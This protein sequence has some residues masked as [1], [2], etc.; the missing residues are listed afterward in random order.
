MIQTEQDLYDGNGVGDG[1]LPQVT[2]YADSSSSDNRVTQFA[3][4][5]RDRLVATKSGVQASEDTTTHRP[6]MYYDLDNLGEVTGISHYDGDGVTLTNTKPSA[7]LL[8]AHEADSYDD[9]GRVYQTQQYDVNQTTR[10]LSP[11]AL[12]PNCYYD[13]RGDLIA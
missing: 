9:Q 6:I 10:A 13:H 4:D 1:N 2:Q 3:Y 11:T 7:S 5:G 8:R 12:T